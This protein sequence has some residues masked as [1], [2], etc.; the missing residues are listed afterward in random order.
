MRKN[1]IILQ[2]LLVLAVLFGGCATAG[3]VDRDDYSILCSAVSACSY[4]MIGEYGDAIPDD[5][6]AETVLSVCEKNMPRNYYAEL[7]K[8]HLQVKPKGTYYLLLVYNREGKTLIMFDY[9]C[10]PACDG[11]VV[12]EPDKYN[13]NNIESY[14]PCKVPAEK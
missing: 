8:H 6:T 9:S 14:D 12:I 11:K 13:V 2:I 5:I 1:S 10:T 7:K 3:Q 4:A